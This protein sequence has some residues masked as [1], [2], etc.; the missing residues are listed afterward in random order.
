[1]TRDATTSLARRPGGPGGRRRSGTTLLELLVTIALIAI[2]A[3][4]VAPALPRLGDPAPDTPAS[5]IARARRDALASGRPVTVS[6]DTVVAPA[7]APPVDATVSPDGSV[8][9]DTAL[10]IDRLSGRPADDSR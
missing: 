10:S 4:V 7:Q 9:A 6:I 8:V 5:R 3:G 1:M 2:V